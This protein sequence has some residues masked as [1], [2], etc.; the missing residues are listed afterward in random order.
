MGTL[1]MIMKIRKKISPIP[2]D[3]GDYIAYSEESSTGL[4]WR[5][6]RGSNLVK[7][8]EAGTLNSRGRLQVKFKRRRYMNY[9]IIY[10]LNTGIDPEEKQV[11]HIDG[12]YLNN[13]ISNLR[14]ATSEQ[15]QHNRKKSKNNTSG[16]TGVSWC[17][18]EKKHNSF[19]RCNGKLFNLG[20][21]N[22][23]D[24]AVAVRIAAETDPRFKDQEYRNSHNDQYKLTPEMLEWG[25]KYLEDRMKKLNWDI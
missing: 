8:Q 23:S 6:N 15:N 4:V 25:K 1:G 18:R 14:L 21:F 2:K 5:C 3:I 22:K 16:I 12:N 11:D 13:K 7:G 19:I 20:Y 10:F 9:R 24:E 17:K